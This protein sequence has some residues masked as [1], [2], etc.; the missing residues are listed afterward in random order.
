MHGLSAILS[1]LLTI[2]VACNTAFSADPAA[3]KQRYDS[4]V[5]NLDTG[6]D[7]L[8]VANLEGCMQGLV[9]NISQF[10][11]A[12]PQT[13]QDSAAIQN[14]FNK[15]P[16][17]LQ[18]N[19]F[20][21]VQGFGMSVVPRTDGLN[22]V[23]E[24]IGRD[25]AAAGLPLWRGLVGGQPRTLLCAGFIPEDTV[26]VRTGTGEIAQFWKLIRAGVAEFASPA[27]NAGF[28][29]Q[30]S[31]LSTNMGVNIDK[32]LESIGNEGLFSIQLSRTNLIDIPS[33]HGAPVKMPCPSLLIVLAVKDNTLI[34]AMEQ[35]LARAGMPVIR[36]ECESISV[37]SINLP[38]PLPIPFQ[39]AFAVCSNFFLLGSSPAVV[40]D[41]VK[42]FKA[43]NG[44]VATPEYK[45]AFAG[46]P[47][48][49]NGI[50]YMSPRFTK[51]IMDL[52]AT[53]ME[54][55]EG[56]ENGGSPAAI[57]ALFGAKA[58]TKSAFV[59]QNRPDGILS[60]GI[61]SSGGKEMAGALLVAPIGVMAGIAIPSFVKARST[62]QGHAC[63]NNLRMIEAAKEQWALS[64][65][66]KEGDPVDVPGI[67]HYIKGD[68]IPVCP[69]GGT[70]KINAIG[71][72]AE[73]TIPGHKMP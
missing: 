9:S 6:G 10:V 4:I 24:F 27:G 12:L 62:A 54:S 26:L 68:K 69:Q 56:P 58:D 5:A 33:S 70:Y 39:P 13:D 36:T 53:L 59:V 28:E 11:A 17:F 67:S 22:T 2:V 31:N 1:V 42:A 65:N 25:R 66:K 41:A 45:Q 38:M 72:N 16:Q 23:K 51:S 71:V 34:K 44:L 60:A 29:R 50:F 30:L 63:V 35:P 37:S 3:S 15:I 7:I 49:N 55:A 20:Y 57:S 52:Q 73:C 46:L 32:I 21:A 47:A 8:V 14:T 61:T 64:E 43:N 48:V 40:S 19:G 18:R